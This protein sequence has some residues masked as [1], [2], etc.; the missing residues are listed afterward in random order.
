MPCLITS[1]EQGMRWKDAPI[2]KALTKL[3]DDKGVKIIT[4]VWQAGGIVSKDQ[5]DHRSR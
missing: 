4:W 1:Y 5:A 3:L 2:G